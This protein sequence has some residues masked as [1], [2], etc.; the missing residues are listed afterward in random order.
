MPKKIEKGVL[1]CK[2]LTMDYEKIWLG[3]NKK[4]ETWLWLNL[5]LHYITWHEHEHQWQTLKHMDD[6]EDQAEC[7]GEPG[8]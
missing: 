4:K 2:N 7:M 1:N 8:N 3:L 5:T 6:G